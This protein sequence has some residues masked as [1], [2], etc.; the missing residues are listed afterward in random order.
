M[1]KKKISI[2]Y[3]IGDSSLTGAPRHLLSLVTGLD[4]KEFSVSVILPQGPLA[5]ELNNHR[6][7]TFLVPMRSRSDVAAVNAIRKL[8][9]KYDPDIMHAHGQRAG[10]LARL[11]VK[12]LPIKVVYTE[13]T[14]TKEFKLDNPLLHWAHIRSMRMLDKI[15]HKTIAVSKAV[16]DFLLSAHITKPDKIQVIYNGIELLSD[17][18][19]H[20]EF[21]LL[22]KY[23]LGLK[24]VV[25]GTIGSMNIQK[26]TASLIKAMPR[27]LKRFPNAKLVI[28][29]SGP[30]Q[31]Y[32]QRLTQK[33]KV[34]E[35]V[36]FTGVINNVAD[37]LKTF[38]VFV[39]CSKSEAFGISILE[40]MKAHV[41]IVATK[42]G[43]IPEIITSNRNGL[44]VSPGDSKQLASTIMKLLNDKKLQKKLAVGGY[45]T[46]QK[47]TTTT[48][49]RET[50]KLYKQLVR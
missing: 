36:V 19:L 7:T 3:V 2:T 15:T 47:F 40:A 46:L 10:L 20:S 12:D 41:P 25:I 37:I 16:A 29:G 50:E 44:L 14:W 38:S 32:L 9:I 18:P 11:A 27:V 8:L 1:A 33:L 49:V 24:D 34:A 5:A 21:E 28:V 39:L 13:H 43:G 31:K 35:A 22:R 6:I 4:P 17:K 26:D 45:D 30:L 42:V 23:S 48:M